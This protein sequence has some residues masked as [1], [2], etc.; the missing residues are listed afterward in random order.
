MLIIVWNFVVFFVFLNCLLCVL[1]VLCVLF[2]AFSP[3][4]AGPPLRR[5]TLLLTA[6]RRTTQNFALFFSL[7]R[8][9]FALFVS[10]WVSS[11]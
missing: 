4:S 7:S 11:R 9:I 6:L 3:P 5:T 2:C 10:L 8:T 1:C